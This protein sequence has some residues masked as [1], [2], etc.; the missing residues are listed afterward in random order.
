MRYMCL[1]EMMMKIA[2]IFLF[3]IFMYS[4]LC[5][6]SPKMPDTPKG[7]NGPSQPKFLC[8]LE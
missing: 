5:M 6:E 4:T 1:K 2:K 7:P 8:I 3:A